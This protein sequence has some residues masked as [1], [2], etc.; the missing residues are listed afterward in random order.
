MGSQ[1]NRDQQ[2]CSW[3]FKECSFQVWGLNKTTEYWRITTK[4]N[5][6]KNVFSRTKLETSEEACMSSTRK[7]GC[8]Q[9]LQTLQRAAVMGCFC[10]MLIATPRLTWNA[11]AQV[12]GTAL[13]WEESFQQVFF[14]PSHSGPAFTPPCTADTHSNHYL[15]AWNYPL[16]GKKSEIC[17]WAAKDP[18]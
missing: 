7:I 18:E 17:Q 4:P 15:W 5:S 6:C 1:R 10:H 13:L 11:S 3:Q 2:K 16:G 8:L 14:T 12:L 9:L